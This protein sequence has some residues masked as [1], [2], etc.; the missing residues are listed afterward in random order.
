MFANGKDSAVSNVWI[1][2][3]CV[4]CVVFKL[5]IMNFSKDLNIWNKLHIMNFSKDLNIWNNS[6]H[7]IFHLNEII[8]STL[9]RVR[10]IYKKI[11]AIVCAT[12][13][14]AFDDF[15]NE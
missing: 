13:R 15:T 12:I 11:S 8:L 7:C 6:V 2:S 1:E 3:E 14:S 5:H 10:Y 4:M 9:R